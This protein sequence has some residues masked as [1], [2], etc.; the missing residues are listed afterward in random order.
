MSPAVPLINIPPNPIDIVLHVFYDMKRPQLID[1]DDDTNGLDTIPEQYHE[2]VLQPG[3]IRLIRMDQENWTAVQA[4]DAAFQKGLRQMATAE[5]AGKE[6][7]QRMP[8]FHG[9]H[10]AW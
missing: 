7:V 4:Y 2:D 10:R 3:A 6:R 9:T 5:T 8:R 1:I